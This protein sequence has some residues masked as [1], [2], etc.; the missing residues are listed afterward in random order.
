MKLI[1]I[2]ESHNRLRITC[3]ILL[4]IIACNELVIIAC[5]EVER[6]KARRPIMLPNY[7]VEKQIRSLQRR[8]GAKEDGIVGYETLTKINAAITAERK[9]AEIEKSSEMAEHYFVG[10]QA[11]FEKAKKELGK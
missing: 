4:V 8:V 10:Q 11:E 9:K 7:T 6:H 3:V 5:N 1:E 2:T